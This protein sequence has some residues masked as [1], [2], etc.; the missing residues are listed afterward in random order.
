MIT[1]TAK[2]PAATN[3][4]PL[5]SALQ[6]GR[7]DLVLRYFEPLYIVPSIVEECHRHGAGDELRQL[8]N[9]GSIV[10]IED[11]SDEEQQ[12]A[13]RIAEQI[14]T[15]PYSNV[16]NSCHHLPEAQIMVMAARADLG[17]EVVLLEERAAREIGQAMGL[18]VTGFVGV[19]IKA[20]HE[21]L[22]VPN[23]IRVLLEECR[24]KGT[25]YT[26]ALI[27][28]AMFTSF[29]SLLRKLPTSGR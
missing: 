29:S 27:E 7:V 4:G 3:T 23:K 21:G 17:C 2:T 13:W 11:L 22:L 19:L 14:A 26:D 28:A 9:V 8:I 6:C 16:P 20:A 25:R 15:S 18:E 24:S 1:R 12:R 5:L 10:V